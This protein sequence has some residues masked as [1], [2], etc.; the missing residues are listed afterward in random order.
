M[1]G[2]EGNM[3]VLLPEYDA[4]IVIAATSYNDD[5]AFDHSVAIVENYVIP[6]LERRMQSAR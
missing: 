3:A 2:N 4:V 6:E 5:D 1:L